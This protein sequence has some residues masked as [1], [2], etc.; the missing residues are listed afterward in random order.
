MALAAALSAPAASAA[1]PAD[2]SMEGTGP[3]PK[4]V[5]LFSDAALAQEGCAEN[6][7]MSFTYEG[8]GQ[9]CV[10]PWPAGKKNGGAT[11][12]G[13]SATEV[14]VVAYLPNEQMLGE[15]TAA[16]PKN[17]ASGDP[18]PLQDVMRDWQRVYEYAVETYGAYQLWGRNARPRERDRQWRR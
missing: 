13:V 12:E 14:K 9:W 8:S 16:G 18:A 6:G 4:G 11:A 7:R 2:V 10:N 1:P 3:A 5:G 17:Q 15:E